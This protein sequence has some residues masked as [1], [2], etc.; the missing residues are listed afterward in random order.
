MPEEV[1]EEVQPE[2]LPWDEQ[3]TAKIVNVSM[4]GLVTIQFNTPIREIYNWT[5][6]NSSIVDMYIDPSRNREFEENFNASQLNFT[7]QV[8]RILKDYMFIQLNFTNPYEI[9][10]ETIQDK[11]VFHVT[12][13]G[14]PFF[15]TLRLGE[16][17][18]LK[19]QTLKQ[20]VPKQMENSE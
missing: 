11:L 7:W 16:T 17:L 15:K 8:E 14:L 5:H 18:P 3:F 10:P 6:I 20:L 1:I 12:T 2:I 19:Y 4:I 13:P 9:S